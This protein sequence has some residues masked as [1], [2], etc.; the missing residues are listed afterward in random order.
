[1][2]KRMTR[3]M[4]M[5]QIKK[6]GQARRE[7]QKVSLMVVDAK[8]GEDDDV[9]GVMN[10]MEQTEVIAPTDASRNTRIQ[11]TAMNWK[12]KPRTRAAMQNKEWRNWTR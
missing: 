12:M 11:M 10:A 1:M 9:D 3:Q 8:H 5:N 6:R 4:M 7:R 2:T